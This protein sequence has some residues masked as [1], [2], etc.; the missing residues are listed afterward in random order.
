MEIS[1]KIRRAGV[2]IGLTAVAAT[3]AGLA[4]AGPASAA[5]A[6]VSTPAATPTVKVEFAIAAQ[7]VK[8]GVTSVVIKA[9]GG[10]GAVLGVFPLH[11]DGTATDI[12]VSVPV[13]SRTDAV[14]YLK[15]NGTDPA[16]ASKIVELGLPDHAFPATGEQVDVSY[17]NATRPTT[18]TGSD[19][20]VKNGATVTVLK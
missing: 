5:T 17:G 19:A 15:N 9:A 20:L 11:T 7:S 6:P 12:V 16:T 10:N 8:A 3:V 14:P 13:N 1:A 4:L 2:G 18:A